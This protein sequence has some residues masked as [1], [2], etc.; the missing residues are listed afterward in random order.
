MTPEVCDDDAERLR[1]SSQTFRAEA[2][3]V[4]EAA[5]GREVAVLGEDG[6]ERL[7]IIR[8]LAPLE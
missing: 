3:S 2:A 4:M 8:K 6:E 5:L 1:V 7:L